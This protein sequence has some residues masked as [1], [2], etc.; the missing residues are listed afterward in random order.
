[1]APSKESG[2]GPRLVTVGCEAA[3]NIR[4][5]F[6]PTPGVD[7]LVEEVGSLVGG[8][9]CPVA[10]ADLLVSEGEWTAR[11]WG[12]LSDTA[13]Q[14]I[15]CCDGLAGGQEEA[16]IGGAELCFAEP[17]EVDGG[18]GTVIALQGG[19]LFVD[20]PVNPSAGAV[21]PPVT[22]SQSEAVF[23]QRASKHQLLLRE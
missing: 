8:L 21:N 1:M 2:L 5:G 15:G 16:A 13:F 20:P 4:E 18:V 9:G 7:V 3:V 10:V 23:P 19:P 6:D 11:S 14:G 17:L 12:W 22:D